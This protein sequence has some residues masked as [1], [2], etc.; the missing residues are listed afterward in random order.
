MRPFHDTVPAVVIISFDWDGRMII[1]GELRRRRS[2]FVSKY[3]SVI[4]LARLSEERKTSVETA[5]NPVG[6]CDGYIQV[7]YNL[8]WH[9]HYPVTWFTSLLSFMILMMMGN[10]YIAPVVCICG[11]GA[12]I[13][14]GGMSND[15]LISVWATFP[16][17]LHAIRETL[18]SWTLEQ[19]NKNKT[20]RLLLTA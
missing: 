13:A 4:R 17:H 2:W 5:G 9:V 7:N 12:K 3:Y 6:I 11:R 20:R 8:P 18:I 16:V 15:I 19:L 1:N 10:T 14:T